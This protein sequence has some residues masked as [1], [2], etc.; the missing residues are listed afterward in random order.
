MPIF[1]INSFRQYWRSI[2]HRCFLFLVHREEMPINSLSPLRSTGQFEHANTIMMHYLCRSL[3]NVEEPATVFE[4]NKN[5]AK[6]HLCSVQQG[7]FLEEDRWSSERVEVKSW[8]DTICYNC[9][10]Q[11]CSIGTRTNDAKTLLLPVY[12][13]SNKSIV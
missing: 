13:S 2:H 8:F 11:K 3:S 6:L 4:R 7:V 5:Y 9:D 12:S 1:E 10:S